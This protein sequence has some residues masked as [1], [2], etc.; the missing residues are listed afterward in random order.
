MKPGRFWETLQSDQ[1]VQRES[2][3]KATR[4]PA[5]PSP[6][7]V[8]G[9][10]QKYTVGSDGSTLHQQHHIIQ[11]PGLSESRQAVQQAAD[12]GWTCVGP[13][14]QAV[15]RG[16]APS[17]RPPLSILSHRTVL[18]SGLRQSSGSY[19]RHFER[20]PSRH[21]TQRTRQEE[22]GSYRAVTVLCDVT[23]L[24]HNH[25][26]AWKQTS[27]C[28]GTNTRTCRGAAATQLILV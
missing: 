18:I 20:I 24:H 28:F 25:D 2:K 19:S 22:E 6:K 14:A 4:R 23:E 12:I 1:R 17:P 15:G 5:R 11:N 27:D 16:S 21:C 8:T 26:R 13:S 7:I 9:R 3:S 10:C